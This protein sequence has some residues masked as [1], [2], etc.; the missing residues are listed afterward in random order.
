MSFDVH[1]ECLT[2]GELDLFPTFWAINRHCEQVLAQPMK[3]FVSSACS[4][5]SFTGTEFW[6]SEMKKIKSG[7]K[8]SLI[9]ED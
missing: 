9:G 6:Q 4:S 3:I 7:K 2:L 8:M 1:I 5:V